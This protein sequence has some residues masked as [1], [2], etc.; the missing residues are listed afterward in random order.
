MAASKSSHKLRNFVIVLLALWSIVSLIIIVVWATSPD[1]KGA[2]ECNANLKTLK[3]KIAEEK[4]TW[5]KDRHALEEL[6]RQ[7][8]INQSLLLTHIDQLKEQLQ[9]L[10]Q[11]LDS[12]L[13]QNVSVSGCWFLACRYYGLNNGHL[14]GYLVLGVF[15]SAFYN[16]CS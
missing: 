3:E 12:C 14:T 9:F 5:T 6:V 13:Q 10:N 16:M 2:S 4:T 7:G 1:L 8:H 15:L 11:S